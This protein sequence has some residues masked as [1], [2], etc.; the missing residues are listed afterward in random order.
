MVDAGRRAIEARL[1]TI[2]DH[3]SSVAFAPPLLLC[4]RVGSW[5]SVSARRV[6]DIADGSPDVL[7]KLYLL[8]E[9]GRPLVP[10]VIPVPMVGVCV[11]G[12]VSAFR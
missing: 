5:N 7:G 9:C 12:R 2:T 1:A 10:R 3:K 11:C 4:A 6:G 8:G